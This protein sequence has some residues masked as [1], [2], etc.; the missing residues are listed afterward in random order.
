[1]RRKPGEHRR[2]VGWLRVSS[3]VGTFGPVTDNGD[4]TYTATFTATS[5]GSATFAATINGQPVTSLPA[6]I[7]VVPLSLADS[8][9]TVTPSTIP[10]DGT[11]IVTLTAGDAD[12]TQ[13]TTGGLTVA[14][15][16]G[17]G[18]GTGTFGPVTDNGNGTYT[19]TF[20]AHTV[21]TNT[22]FATIDGFP[23]STAATLTINPPSTTTIVGS[24]L[25]PC[26]AGQFV[27]FTATVTAIT[28]D[29]PT[30]T[31]LVQFLIDGVDFGATDP[32]C[33][34]HSH[35][36]EHCEPLGRESRRDGRIPERRPLIHVRP[37]HP[38]RRRDSR[39]RE[40]VGLRGFDRQGVAIRS[41]A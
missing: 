19:A 1:M 29:V 10:V 2:P 37:G 7:I 16:L 21:G 24:S 23:I 34:R 41:S 6:G 3:A 31:G 11:T 18:T 20:S 5:P 8:S 40:R 35:K 13:E 12:D 36:R 9:V 30:P 17:S 22:I 38:H 4:G 28:A 25:N 32:P 15:A 26:L 33:Q 14:F 27:R 39:F